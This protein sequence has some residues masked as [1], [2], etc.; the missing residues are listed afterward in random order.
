[1]KTVDFSEKIEACELKVGRYRQLIVFM[2]VFE[3]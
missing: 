2:K 3:Y 1:M